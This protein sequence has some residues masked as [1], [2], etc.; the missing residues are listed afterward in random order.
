M[1]VKILTTTNHTF[2]HCV[3]CVGIRIS[4][5]WNLRAPRVC[6]EIRVL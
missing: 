6:L 1:F 3:H 4:L 5:R 2:Q